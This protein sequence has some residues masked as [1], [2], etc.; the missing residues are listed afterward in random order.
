MMKLIINSVKNK[1]EERKTAILLEERKTAILLE[2]S[3]NA[4]L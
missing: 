3:K 2:E 1:R 4:S